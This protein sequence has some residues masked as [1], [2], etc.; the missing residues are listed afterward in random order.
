VDP[1]LAKE[2]SVYLRFI[3]LFLGGV[4]LKNFKPMSM[5]E[6]FT[7]FQVRFRFLFYHYIKGVSTCVDTNLGKEKK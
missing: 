3:L 5:V 4:L 1:L 7:K 6:V 2:D